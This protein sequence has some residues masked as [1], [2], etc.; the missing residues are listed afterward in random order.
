MVPTPLFEKQNRGLMIGKTPRGDASGLL[1]P[2]Q[3]DKIDE[4]TRD[5]L[6]LIRS[7]YE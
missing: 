7:V 1:C 4:R 3:I 2:V 6:A 5:A